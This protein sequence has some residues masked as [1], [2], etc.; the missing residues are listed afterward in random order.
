MLTQELVSS[1]LQ[2]L[3]L[4]I[5]TEG[6]G[7]PYFN[8]KSYKM[9]V[10]IQNYSDKSSCFRMTTIIDTTD[11]G[12]VFHRMHSMDTINRTVKLVKLHFVN[13]LAN[14]AATFDTCT[15]DKAELKHFIEQSLRTLEL[16]VPY[17]HE[18][19]NRFLSLGS[20]KEQQRERI[21]EIN[22]DL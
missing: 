20:E 7:E 5:R 15:S 3:G 17:Y 10:S 21:Q 16:V 19:K 12:L 9:N 13:M 18:L 8:F 6:D 4:V 1:V 22:N 14:M 2:E 11:D